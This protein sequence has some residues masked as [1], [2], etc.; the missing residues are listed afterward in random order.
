MIKPI[1]NLVNNDRDVQVIGRIERVILSTGSNG[2]NYMII[3]LV[4]QSG[5][6]E[7]RK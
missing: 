7:A 2:Q 4:D 5:R 3:N 6:I 1:A